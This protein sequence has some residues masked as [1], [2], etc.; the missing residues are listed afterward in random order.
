MK[1]YVERIRGNAKVQ[2]YLT[3]SELDRLVKFLIEVVYVLQGDSVPYC[4]VLTPDMI[5]VEENEAILRFKLGF[6]LL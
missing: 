6:P 4:T 1:S 3:L 2:P 5:L